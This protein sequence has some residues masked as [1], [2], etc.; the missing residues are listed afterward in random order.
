MGL[1]DEARDL[2]D[3]ALAI[4]PDHTDARRL[5]QRVSDELE[6]RRLDQRRQQAIRSAREHLAAK[7]FAEALAILDEIDREQPEASGVTDLR[8]EI[9]HKQAEE[10]RRL[11]TEEFNL[12][13]A[14]TR[15]AMQAGEL[16]LAGPMM[17]HL[18]GNFAA[19]PGAADVLPGLRQ[20]LHALICTKEI[21]QGPQHH[22]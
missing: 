19:E 2:F 10:G 12:A 20:R 14:R 4:D 15:E 8:A 22:G 5:C 7:Q 11:R 3:A 13:L 6:R 16:E 17:D 9:Q 1:L 21:A 18:V